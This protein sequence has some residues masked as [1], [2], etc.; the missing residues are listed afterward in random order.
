MYQDTAC[1]NPFELAFTFLWLMF[2]RSVVHQCARA[3]SP[4]ISE[5][6]LEVTTN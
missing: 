2:K 4:R 3:I 6:L 5:G 1:I